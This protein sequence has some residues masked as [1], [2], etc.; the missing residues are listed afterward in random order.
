MAY[1]T[2][3]DPSA[4]FQTTLYTGNGSSGHEITNS[5]NSNLKPDW[6][7]IKSRSDTEQHTLYDS[8]RGST[9]RL[10]SDAT[11]AEYVNSTQGI[12]SFNTDGFTLGENDQ[13]NKSSQNCVAWQ[14]KANGGTTSSFTESGSNPGGNYQANT[15]AGF[16]IVTYTGTGSNGTVQHGLSSA[17]E[18]VIVKQRD[19]AAH[20]WQTGSDFLTSW[21]YRLKLNDDVTEASVATSFN[22]TA[23]TSSVFTVGS[24]D[25]VNEDAHG[26]VGYCFH[27]VKGYSKIGS[28]KGNGNADG[29]FVYTGFKPA[30]LMWKRTDSGTDWRIFDNKRDDDNVVKGRLFPNTT[31]SE[32]T[33]QDTLDFLSNGF[34]LRSTN[35]GGN[36]SGGTY[37]YMAFAEHP[38]VSSKGV[39]VTAR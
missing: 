10:M 2:I 30:W 32:N 7:W 17:P 26:Y 35:S 38:F 12:Q 8:S 9:K 3:D 11:N 33:S 34:K 28:Y 20:D 13:N 27:S 36:A 16:S 6:L 21:A 37:I 19:D 22:S 39:P 23:P 15:T 24:N 4:H 5:G 18:L 31:D 25:D 14:W 29:P 1:T